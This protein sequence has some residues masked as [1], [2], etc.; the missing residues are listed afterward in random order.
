M[1]PQRYIIRTVQWHVATI[2]YDE[3]NATDVKSVDETYIICGIE[4]KLPKHPIGNLL[5]F[6]SL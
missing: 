2:N 1:T 4:E 6:Q 3:T 5:N